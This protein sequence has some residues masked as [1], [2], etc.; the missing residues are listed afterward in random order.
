MKIAHGPASPSGVTSLM[1]VGAVV[2]DLAEL[3][4][5]DASQAFSLATKIAVASWVFGAAMGNKRAKDLG[6][7]A[8][9]GLFLARLVIR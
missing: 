2:D 1:H 9:V 7:K 6:F 5:I 8:S 4:G 3:D